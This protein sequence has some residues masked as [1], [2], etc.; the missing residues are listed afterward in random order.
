M[1]LG[2]NGKVFAVTDTI[3]GTITQAMT[4]ARLQA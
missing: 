3:E 4:R 2:K 1:F